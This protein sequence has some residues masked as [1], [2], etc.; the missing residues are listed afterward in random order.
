MT[1]ENNTQKV[2]LQLNTKVE[3]VGQYV[4]ERTS[5]VN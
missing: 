2:T 1:Y 3:R 4:L 5:G